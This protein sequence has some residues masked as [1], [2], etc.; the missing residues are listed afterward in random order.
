MEYKVKIK[1][2]KY[3]THDV[4]QFTVEKP[5]GFN[6]KAGQA[7]EAS[8][9]DPKFKNDWAPFTMTS[10]NS[11][12]FLQFTIKIYRE[13]NG[14][15]EALS[16]LNTVDHFLIT[17]PW[18]SFISKG[19]GVF[20]AGGTGVTPFIALLRQMYV[21]GTVGD[22]TLL[23]SNKTENDIFLAE[24]FKKILGDHFINIITHDEI[25]NNLFIYVDPIILQRKL[26][27]IW[28]NLE[29]EKNW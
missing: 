6:Y 22:S 24:E 21:D 29:Q 16:K 10:I 2:K 19:P 14:M 23:F 15:T 9:V 3:L 26:K 28:V 25:S 7:V 27:V 4:I 18:D 8:I 1:D 17:D 20:I 11:D 13:H 5:E 12:E